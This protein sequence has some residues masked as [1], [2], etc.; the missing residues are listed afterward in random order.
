MKPKTLFIY[1]IILLNGSCNSLYYHVE[2]LD[3]N[4]E[5]IKKGK[6]ESVIFSKDADCFLCNLGVSRFT[7]TLQEINEAEEILKKNIKSA[8]DPMY[9]QGEECPIIHENLKNYR[10]QYYGYIDNKG[11]KILHVNFLWA[12][13]SVIDRLKGNYT[14][15]SE[16]WKKQRVIILDG[17]SHYWSIDINITA[18]TLHNMNVNG[19]A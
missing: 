3:S 6:I 15:D 12:R 1:L 7:P 4:V 19:S 9:N 10:R 2:S 5:L 17:C 8:N 16:S 13:Y 14:D 11:H 18:H